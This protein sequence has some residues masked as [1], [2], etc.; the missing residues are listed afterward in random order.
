M[1]SVNF[2]QNLDLTSSRERVCSLALALYRVTNK[3]P[4]TEPMRVKL[5]KEI[6]TLI[7][8]VEKVFGGNVKKYSV[9]LSTSQTLMHYCDIARQQNWLDERNF[10]VL[11]DEFESVQKLVE[12]SLEIPKVELSP[13]FESENENDGNEETF[14]NIFSKIEKEQETPEAVSSIVKVEDLTGRQKVLLDFITQKKVAK[15]G[16]LENIA[17]DVTDRTLRRD[18]EALAKMGYIRKFGRTNRTYYKLVRTENSIA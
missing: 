6:L 9:F 10:V 5:R 12:N 2:E 13:T 11:K 18:M 3:M 15:I 7:S 8:T 14:E 16:D 17:P 4:E 1:P